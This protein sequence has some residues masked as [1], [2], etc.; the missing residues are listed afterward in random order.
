[1]NLLKRKMHS[2]LRR[3]SRSSA[4]LA[5]SRACLRVVEASSVLNACTSVLVVAAWFCK[6]TRVGC[7]SIASSAAR[8]KWRKCLQ[9]DI[10]FGTSFTRMALVDKSKSQLNNDIGRANVSVAGRALC[11]IAHSHFR[12]KGCELFRNKWLYLLPSPGVK[13]I[14]STLKQVGE[15][16]YSGRMIIRSGHRL[17]EAENPAA[18]M[19][20]LLKYQ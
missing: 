19:T 13:W 11:S 16:S 3:P 5:W 4:A 6:S 15:H 14:P 18:M 17:K 8:S 12:P 7:F 1:M 20:K 10:E 2:W 9:Q